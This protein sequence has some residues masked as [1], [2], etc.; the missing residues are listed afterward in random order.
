MGENNVERKQV[1]LRK[2]TSTA[3]LFTCVETTGERNK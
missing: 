1:F 2:H 3:T